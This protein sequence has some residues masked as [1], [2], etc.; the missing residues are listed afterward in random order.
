M[1]DQSW[2]ELCRRL[3]DNQTTFLLLAYTN[4][5]VCVLAYRAFSLA[6]EGLALWGAYR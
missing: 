3:A 2:A 1:Q 5:L 6:R 4:K